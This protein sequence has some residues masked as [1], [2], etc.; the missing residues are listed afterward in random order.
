MGLYIAI[1]ED[2]NEIVGCEAE[3]E[4]SGSEKKTKRVSERAC[5]ITVA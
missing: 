5:P 1:G 3:P 4:P 2:C